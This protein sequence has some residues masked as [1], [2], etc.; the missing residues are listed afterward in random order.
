MEWPALARLRGTLV[1]LMAVQNLA[2][3]RQASWS[4]T[5]VRRTPLS[6]CPGGD[7]GVGAPGVATLSTVDE[8]VRR[9]GITAPAT[10]VVGEV[11]RNEARASATVLVELL[12]RRLVLLL[13]GTPDR[14]A[15]PGGSQRVSHAKPD[16]AVTTSDQRNLAG[17]I[18]RLI[19]HVASLRGVRI[20]C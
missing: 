11:V 1:L 19:R 8:V 4:T 12:Q 16:T 5:A 7:D 9:E 2:G 14:N 15:S 13:V 10:V 20:R 6:P 18:E 17:E 3:D